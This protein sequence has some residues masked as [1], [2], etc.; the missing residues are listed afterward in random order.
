MKANRRKTLTLEQQVKLQTD[1]SA[2]L[3][4]REIENKYGV[5][6]TTIYNV[7]KKEIN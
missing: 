5:S 3:P 7:L 2:G 4:L 1:Y 6:R